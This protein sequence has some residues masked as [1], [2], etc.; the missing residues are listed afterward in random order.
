[1]YT[2]FVEEEPRKNP[3]RIRESTPFSRLEMILLA[4]C[5]P[6]ILVGLRVAGTCP[7]DITRVAK[8]SDVLRL[9]WS[10]QSLN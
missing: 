5:G 4:F 10:K 7:L 6:E 9:S 1:M 3:V 2:S 8:E